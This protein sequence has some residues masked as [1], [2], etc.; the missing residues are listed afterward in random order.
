MNAGLLPMIRHLR[1]AADGAR[2]RPDSPQAAR[3]AG[4]AARSPF[5]G[6]C[7]AACLAA[8]IAPTTALA[9]NQ[10]SPGLPAPTGQPDASALA[11]RER[12]RAA[13]AA[14]L[15]IAEEEAKAATQA[16]A[17]VEKELRG[18][19]EDRAKLSAVLVETVENVRKAEARAS[20]SEARLRLL[21][22]SEAA[23]RRSLAARRHIIAEVL[24][25]LQRLGRRPPPAVLVAPDD[26]LATVRAAIL[27]GAVVPELRGEVEALAGDLTE[28]ARLRDTTLA[29]RQRAREDVVA[30]AGERARLEGLVA[31]RQTQ[32]RDVERSAD[33]ERERMARLAERVR[34]LR[35]LIAVLDR[36]LALGNR[37]LE[38]RRRALESQL[39]EAR[40][41]LAAAATRDPARLAPRAAFPDLR[42]T[43]PWPVAGRLLR[44]F[45]AP[46]GFGGTIRGMVFQARAG[47]VVTA[48]A[49]ASV[50]YAGPFRSFGRVLI[51]NTSPGYHIVLAG[52]ERTNVEMNQFV[53]AGE[54]LGVLGTQSAS[55]AAAFG[56]DAEGSQSR[57]STGP[58]LYVEF[59]KDGASIDPAPWWAKN[60]AERSL[61]ARDLP[62]R[63]MADVGRPGAA[64]PAGADD[65]AK[66]PDSSGEM[67]AGAAPGDRLQGETAGG[68]R[69]PDPVAV[70]KVRG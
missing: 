35:E 30:L 52:F 7:L 20:A 8:T 11:E 40:D 46:D 65:G 57:D 28:L 64:S 5:L 51:L 24:A 12:E 37:V 61:S 69:L 53:L 19:R 54:P 60:Q 36:E 59:R 13:R 62:G 42:G 26:I 49:D 34:D 25:A 68:E 67:K 32:L 18:L 33:D 6:A 2:L 21:A 17:Q 27:L 31:A 50:A 41:K 70:E 56:G 9:Q 15:R 14:D 45:G 29:E 47:A 1:P 4:R 10:Q 22:D 16:R 66:A 44:P 38:E 43:L 58:L 48:P 23:I 39:R 63:N 55:T 3:P